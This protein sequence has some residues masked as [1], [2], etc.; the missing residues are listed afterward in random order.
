VFE[1][2]F[3]AAFLVETT[4]MGQY[5]STDPDTVV[6]GVNQTA[7]LGKNGHRLLSGGANREQQ[8]CDDGH[9]HTRTENVPLLR[10][11]SPRRRSVW[12]AANTPGIDCMVP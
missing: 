8:P 9:E 6:I 12:M 10:R 7:V 3:G 4:A 5:D 11:W 2:R 1:A